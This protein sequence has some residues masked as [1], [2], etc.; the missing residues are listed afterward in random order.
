[1]RAFR[2]G[3][4]PRQAILRFGRYVC[5]LRFVRSSLLSTFRLVDVADQV[6]VA[7]NHVIERPVLDDAAAGGLP[8]VTAGLSRGQ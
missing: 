5:E 7:A 1:M 8:H 3:L 6:F 4:H 2:S